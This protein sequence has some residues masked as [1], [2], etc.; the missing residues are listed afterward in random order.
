MQISFLLSRYWSETQK[1]FNF[2]NS[3]YESIE[4]RIKNYELR[5]EI[6]NFGLR[7]GI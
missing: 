3:L 7:S 6:Y 4:L 2:A 5:S 1:E